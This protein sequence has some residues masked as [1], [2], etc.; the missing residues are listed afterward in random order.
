MNIRFSQ[1][2]IKLLRKIKRT[3]KGLIDQ[4]NKQLKLFQ[5]H[6]QH[7]S[8]RTHK[9]TGKM[10]NRWSISLSRS[11]RMI[12]ILLKADEAYFV[13]IGTHDKVYR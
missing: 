2:F 13:A 3:D 8:L 12:Y 4:V 1:D 7:P 11:F 6:P 5:L 10:K 9:L